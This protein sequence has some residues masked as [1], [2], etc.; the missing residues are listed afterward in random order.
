MKYM[1][2]YYCVIVLGYL[3]G[4][5]LSAVLYH[6]TS[7]RT[8]FWI[9]FGLSI[10][11]LIFCWKMIYGSDHKLIS[12]Q[13]RVGVL[14]NNNII[15]QKINQFP[16]CIAANEQDTDNVCFEKIQIPRLG[17]YRTAQ[18]L[19]ITLQNAIVFGIDGIFFTYYLDFIRARESHFTHHLYNIDPFP[20]LICLLS[21]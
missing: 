1:K 2:N 8:T 5:I 16:I 10:I 3:C 12:L 17:T 19:N 9:G 14:Y 13:K 11:T 15:T 6:Q 4:P 21:S 18:I 20:C 7:Y